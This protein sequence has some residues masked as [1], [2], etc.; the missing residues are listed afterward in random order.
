MVQ[1]ELSRICNY[2]STCL[3]SEQTLSAH[4]FEEKKEIL[5]LMGE[6]NFFSTEDKCYLMS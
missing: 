4:F 3:Q 1:Y 6:E 2:S 5:P